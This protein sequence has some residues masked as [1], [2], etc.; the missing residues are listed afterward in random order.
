M[1]GWPLRL[2]SGPAGVVRA[3]PG[4]VAQRRE[5]PTHSGAGRQSHLWPP[6][7]PHPAAPSTSTPVLGGSS[8]GLPVGH[9]PVSRPGRPESSPQALPFAG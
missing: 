8:E 2:P 7:S 4:V 1:P 6:P 3:C 5:T 9:W